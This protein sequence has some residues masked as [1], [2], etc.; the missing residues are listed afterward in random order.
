[1]IPKPLIY[2]AIV[3]VTLALFPPAIIARTRAKNSRLPRVHLIQDMDNQPR[4][5]AQQASPLFNDGRAMRPPVPGTVARGEL[6]DEHFE[7][8]VVGH[9]FA[10]TFPPQLTVN[11]ALLERGRERFDIYC[12]VCHGRA[13]YG[14]GMV[15]QRAD[16][17]MK[18]PTLANGTTWVAPK[19]LHEA[20]IRDQP[21]G[22][23]FNTATNGVRNMA[24]YAAQIPTADRWAIVAYVKALQRSQQPR[25]T[26]V[27]DLDDLKVIVE[28]VMTAE[29]AAAAAAA[30]AAPSGTGGPPGGKP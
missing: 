20:A 3:L 16:A 29:E 27:P 4:L 15:H 24:G 5:R 30:A 7:R 14:D 22:Q 19:S 10:T 13:G 25:A 9:G 23:I 2:A 12:S 26:D 21:V 17:L 6:R 11:R 28:I 1:M 8:G 18:T